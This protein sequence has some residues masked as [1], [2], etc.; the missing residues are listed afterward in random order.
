MVPETEFYFSCFIFDLDVGH[1]DGVSV[2]CA[3]HLWFGCF[4]DCGL[5]VDFFQSVS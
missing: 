5:Q 3:D 2:L 4:Q 1:A